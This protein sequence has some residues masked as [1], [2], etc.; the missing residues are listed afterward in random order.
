[1]IRTVEMDSIYIETTNSGN[2]IYVDFKTG[3]GENRKF[4]R[5]KDWGH[6]YL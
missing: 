4:E 2:M 3:T 6:C 5:R 1:M